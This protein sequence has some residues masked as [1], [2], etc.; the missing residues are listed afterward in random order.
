VTKGTMCRSILRRKAVSSSTVQSW[1]VSGPRSDLD[2]DLD[3]RT[4]WLSYWTVA[5]SVLGCGEAR[6]PQTGHPPSLSKS[7][8][9]CATILAVSVLHKPGARVVEAG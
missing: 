7:I 5:A 3:S 8:F 4:S 9:S 2:S 1:V 6:L